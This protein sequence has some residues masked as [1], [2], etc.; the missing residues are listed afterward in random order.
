MV[1]MEYI[2]NERKIVS[3]KVLNE[4][5]KLVLEF[6]GVVEKRVRYMIVSGY[7]AILLGR[8]RATEDVDI[9]I[10]RLD[11]NV[12]ERIFSVLKEAGFY[13]LNCE[14]AMSAFKYLSQGEAIRFAKKRMVI[15]NFE[16]KFMKNSVEEECFK[17][18]LKVE[19]GKK[20]LQVS[21]LELQIVFKEKILK[22]EKDIEDARHLRMVFD[23]KL[24]KE[25]IEYWEREIEK[26]YYG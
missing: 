13:C 6:I 19:M 21:N 16:V 14:A 23:E 1:E 17:Q 12:F 7:V 2:P 26:R 8:S 9:L 22:S 18:C 24:N 3:K 15:P 11:K 10:E 20:V 25:K 4:L 5:D